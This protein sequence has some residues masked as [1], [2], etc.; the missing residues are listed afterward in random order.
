MSRLGGTAS[1][2]FARMQRNDPELLDLY[3]A[4]TDQEFEK[5]FEVLLEKAIDS[6]ER[7]KKNLSDLNEDG[8]TGYLVTALNMTGLTATRETNSNGHV[9]IT[10]DAGF[11]TPMRKKLGEA[12]IYDGPAYHV[13]GLKQ[14]LGRYTTGR[15]GRGLLVTYVKRANIAGLMR[16]IRD[17]MDA[18]RPLKQKGKTQ[19]HSLRWSFISIHRH[20]CGDDLQVGHIGCNL[21][22]ES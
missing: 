13:E 16:K 22:V 3:T 21:H 10:I 14:L 6:S 17:K 4:Q 19:D 18:N 15:E 1:D 9:D 8:L 5:A 11:F 7:D 2:L 12:K 20:S